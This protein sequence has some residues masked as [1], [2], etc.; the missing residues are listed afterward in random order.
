M[1]GSARFAGI[2]LCALALVPG[3]GA[4][5]PTPVAQSGALLTIRGEVV[6]VRYTGGFLD[7]AAHVLRRLDLIVADLQKRGKRPLSVSAYVISREQWEASNLARPYGLPISIAATSVIVPGLGD[8]GTVTSWQHWLGSDLPTLPG[9]PLRGSPEAASSLA[10]ADLF[11]QR[12]IAA[13]FVDRHGLIGRQPWVRGLFTHLVAL[14]LFARYEP[15][16][17]LEIETMYRHLGRQI[18]VLLQLREEAQMPIEQWLLAESRY[19]A[20]AL[21]VHSSQGRKAVRQGLKLRKEGEG[22]LS[23]EAVLQMFPSLRETG[24]SQVDPQAA[25]AVAVEGVE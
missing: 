11:L 10:V 5:P 2:A 23:E 16:R 9:F 7:R 6:V 8:A 25:V 14:E 4:Q 15:S 17:M 1:W 13:I 18:P 3:A 21:R 22:P 12:E 24:L 20:A 19:F